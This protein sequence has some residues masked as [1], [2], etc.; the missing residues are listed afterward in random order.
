MCHPLWYGSE[1]VN[2]ITDISDILSWNAGNVGNVES[3]LL[4][5]LSTL[6]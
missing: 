3:F 6:S 5:H 2:V 1:G 4:F